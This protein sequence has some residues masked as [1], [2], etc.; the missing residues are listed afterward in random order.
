MSNRG[1]VYRMSQVSSKTTTNPS[2][3]PSSYSP[4]AWTHSN[5]L[6]KHKASSGG[7]MLDFYENDYNIK[8]MNSHS[9][10]ISEI[11]PVLQTAELIVDALY[12]YADGR[13]AMLELTKLYKRCTSSQIVGI[14]GEQYH[15]AME[16]VVGS[17][18]ETM[19]ILVNYI[20]RVAGIPGL[21]NLESTW[22]LL[23]LEPNYTCLVGAMTCALNVDMRFISQESPYYIFNTRWIYVVDLSKHPWQARKLRST[24][25]PMEIRPPYTAVNPY[26][27]FEWQSLE[28]MI[29]DDQT[30]KALIALAGIG[31]TDGEVYGPV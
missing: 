24:R 17:W 15:S 6:H 4:D 11:G 16:N 21:D 27:G 29:D 28:Q 8:L 13:P 2:R 18:S 10:S 30:E 5:F 12:S 7:A 25:E 31:G 9:P 22:R 20:D 23:H 3:S 1:R 14:L 19:T 26:A